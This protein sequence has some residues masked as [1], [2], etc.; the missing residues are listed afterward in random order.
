MIQTKYQTIYYGPGQDLPYTLLY[1]RVL[2][3]LLSIDGVE[4]FSS[5]TVNGDTKDI[6]VPVDSVPV[7]KEVHVT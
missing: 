3:L 7:L 4:N 1:N 2:A 5:L 6:T